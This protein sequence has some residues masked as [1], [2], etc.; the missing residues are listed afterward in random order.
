MVRRVL[1]GTTT[2]ES[3]DPLI[4][5]EGDTEEREGE[6]REEREI[7]MKRERERKMFC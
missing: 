3:M 4:V 5:Q 1:T 2:N 7:E 6:G